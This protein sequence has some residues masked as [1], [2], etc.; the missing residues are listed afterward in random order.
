MTLFRRLAV[1]VC[2]LGRCKLN[3]VFSAR[4]CELLAKN[5]SVFNRNKCFIRGFCAAPTQDAVEVDINRLEG[6][7]HG[8]CLVF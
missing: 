1:G 5:I 6:E 2:S 8:R 3:G 4:Q 7:D